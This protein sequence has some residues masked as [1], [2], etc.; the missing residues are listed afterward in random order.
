MN[1]IRYITTGLDNTIDMYIKKKINDNTI[2]N[3]RIKIRKKLN[4]NVDKFKLRS[5]IVKK[6]FLIFDKLYFKNFIQEKLADGNMKIKFDVS[7]KLKNTAGYCRYENNNVKI[8]FSKFIIHKIY[9]D[10]F[11]QINLGGVICN[12]IVDVLIVLMEHEITHLLLF[13]YDKYINDVKSGHNSQFKLLVYN[14]FRHIKITHSLL[15]GDLEKYEQSKKDTY[16]NL[17]IGMKIKCNNKIGIVVDIRDKYI[18]FMNNNKIYGCYFNDYEIIDTNYESYQNHIN[19]LKK[20]LKIGVKIKCSKYNGPITKIT[21]TRIYF[22][23][24]KTSRTAWCLYDVIEL[25]D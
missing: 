18:H 14:M 21:D 3:N 17:K 1:N 8:V 20:K 25:D 13:L 19:N 4:I 24:D 15:F 9:N 5:S 22:K 2:I 23:D 12:D 11:T 10:K 7:N 16:D 6:L